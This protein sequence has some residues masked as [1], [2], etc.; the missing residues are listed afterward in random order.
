MYTYIYIYIDKH[1]Y[2][3]IYI[4]ISYIYIHNLMA[5][6]CHHQFR[7]TKTLRSLA[8]DPGSSIWNLGSS[9]TARRSARGAHFRSGRSDIRHG[10]HMEFLPISDFCYHYLLSLDHLN[11]LKSSSPEVD[12]FF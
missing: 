10:E 1:I 4:S 2:V 8:T 7:G 3:Y 11:H 5:Y 9:S 6:G 12:V